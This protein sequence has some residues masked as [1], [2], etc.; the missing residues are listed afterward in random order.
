MPLSKKGPYN[1]KSNR[2]TKSA[3]LKSHTKSYLSKAQF[4]LKTYKTELKKFNT[5]LNKMI[6]KYSQQ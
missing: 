4:N 2:M 3:V 1:K 5:E 6:N